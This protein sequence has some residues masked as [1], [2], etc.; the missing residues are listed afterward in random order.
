VLVLDEPTD[1][2]DPLGRVEVRRLLEAEL[3]RGATLFVNSH[4]LSETERL[5]VRIGILSRGRLL[6]EGPLEELCRS[7]DTWA[8]R[9]APGAPHAAL[10][11]AGFRPAEE[12]TFSIDAP[13]T[14]ALNTALDRARSAGALLVELT[15][16]SR[17]LEQ[18]LTE[19]L[20]DST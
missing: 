14:V 1:G 3:A 15:R 9:F 4:L 12:G 16:A 17:D 13:D 8:V 18:V 11:A 10:L 5:C 7:E 2:V 20:K 6:R 19:A